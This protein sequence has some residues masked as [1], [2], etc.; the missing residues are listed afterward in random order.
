[1]CPIASNFSFATD[2]QCWASD[3]AQARY[4]SRMHAPDGN[5]R[6]LVSPLGDLH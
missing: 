6:V 3:L 2:C 4:I 5:G 1:M